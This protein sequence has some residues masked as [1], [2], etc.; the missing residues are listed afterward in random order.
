MRAKIERLNALVAHGGDQPCNYRKPCCGEA[1]AGQKAYV[2]SDLILFGIANQT[3]IGGG[4]F[5]PARLSLHAD[6]LLTSPRYIRETRHA[7]RGSTQISGSKRPCSLQ[8]DVCRLYLIVLRRLAFQSWSNMCLTNLLPLD[9]ADAL[10][11]FLESVGQALSLKPM[12]GPG[13]MVSYCA[14]SLGVSTKM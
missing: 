8:G 2:P 1:L 14:V 10:R 12:L 3:S 13:Q 11:P 5:I 9:Q 6:F 4:T 7:G